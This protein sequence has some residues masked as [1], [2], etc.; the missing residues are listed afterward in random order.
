MA[1]LQGV[2]QTTEIFCLR[3]PLRALIGF[4]WLHALHCA[5]ASVLSTRTWRT[6]TSHFVGMLFVQFALVFEQ[7]CA[8]YVVILPQLSKRQWRRNQCVL[9][10]RKFYIG[11]TS[12]SVHSRQ[13]ACVR[14]LR[15]LSQGHFTNTEM[16]VHYFH[17]KADFYTTIIFP[18]RVYPTVSLARSAECNLIHVWKP[19]LNMPWIAALNPTSAT[20]QSVPKLVSSV[21]STPGRRLWLRVRRRLRTLGILR[22]YSSAPTQPKD[23]WSLLVT[24]SQG[25][26]QAFEMESYLRSAQV[27]TLHIYGLLRMCNLLDDPP[28]TAVKAALKRTLGFRQ[29][30]VPRPSKPLCVP[31]LAHQEFKKNLQSW[32]TFLTKKFTNFLTPFHLPGKS[33]VAGTHPSFKSVLYNNI[34]LAGSWSWDVPPTCKCA[35]W[36]LQHPNLEY[37]DGH[38]A[39][40][41]SLLSLSSRLRNFL[42]YSAE[43]QVYPKKQNYIQQT[44]PTILAW[45]RH[46]GLCD[47]KFTDWVAFVENEWTRHEASA[48]TALKFKDVQFLRNILKDFFIHGRD[49]ALSHAHVFCPYFAWTIYKKTFGDTMVYES[50]LMSPM[51]ASV[52]LSLSTKKRFLKTYKWGINAT[53]SSLPIAYLLLKRKKQYKAARP[54]ISYSHFIYAKLFRA[55]A[56]VLDLLVRAVCPLSFGLQTL[57]QMLQNLRGFLQGLPEDFDPATFNQDLVGFFTSIPVSRILSSVE[58][59]IHKYCLQQSVDLQTTQFSV[60]LQE[61][62]VKLR[63]WRGRPRKGARRT[64]SIFLK[65]VLSI[66]Q[67]SCECSVFTVMGRTFRQ[68]RGATIGNQISPMLANLTVS[69]VEQKFAEQYSRQLKQMADHFFCVRYVDNRLLIIDQRWMRLR[70]M[71]EF[72][73]DFFYG[74][75]VELES[76][77]A[78][79][80]EQEFLG[81][82]VQVL[83][84]SIAVLQRDEPW[85]VRICNSAGVRA[86]K[87]AAYFSKKYSILRYTW[88]PDAR[89]TQ[90]QSLQNMFVQAGYSL[91]DLS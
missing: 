19:A 77:L 30:P 46:H 10:S 52:F 2:Q 58:E 40:P 50:L 82:D 4:L 18:L 67:L 43:S 26:K 87:L 74:S 15:L 5:D 20:R 70:C 64:Y 41:A 66:C 71:Q 89:Q 88:P 37:T 35:E 6:R 17:C 86:Q 21:Y 39:S 76:V 61:K 3:K 38:V 32:I 85:K 69:L 11:S 90:L 42:H 62:D 68:R 27:S 7:P 59:I 91:A 63:I 65:D 53:T 55:T 13:D 29:A 33:V 81:F 60:V 75:P 36:K 28:R 25:G 54:I 8:T 47:V 49:H 24:L 31:M 9:D 44:W 22:L 83:R 80:V 1:L 51:Q 56:I 23:C 34:T 84:A 73:S 14:K 78:T 16:M 57:P 12:V 48:L 45:A 72:C 79:D